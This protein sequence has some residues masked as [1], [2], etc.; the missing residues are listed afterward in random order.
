MSLT[1][2]RPERFPQPA[3]YRFYRQVY[4]YSEKK[5]DSRDA[6]MINKADFTNN[7]FIE[8]LHDVMPE[9]YRPWCRGFRA[10]ELLKKAAGLPS[11]SWWLP[12]T[13]TR[14]IG[15]CYENG[16]EKRQDEFL[17][18]FNR[19][20]PDSP[21]YN[22]GRV[23]AGTCET[24]DNCSCK[25]PE[26]GTPLPTQVLDF[27]FQKM[28]DRFTGMSKEEMIVLMGAHNLGAIHK[29]NSGFSTG[30]WMPDSDKLHVTFLH[31]MTKWAY[32]WEQHNVTNAVT[33]EENF[34]FHALGMEG[35][36]AKREPLPG[37]PNGYP[38]DCDEECYRE[39]RYHIDTN[40][41]IFANTFHHSDGT[42]K[43][44]S[45]IENVPSGYQQCAPQRCREDYDQGKDLQELFDWKPESVDPPRNFTRIS[46]V[47]DISM[48][49]NMSL[50]V[51]GQVI[52]GNG[53]V[54]R[55][56]RE[57]DYRADTFPFPMSK[58]FNSRLNRWNADDYSG[59]GRP[60][61]VQDSRYQRNQ[62]Y[63]ADFQ[64]D[65]WGAFDKMTKNG[66][67]GDFSGDE[68]LGSIISTADQTEKV[69]DLCSRLSFD[70]D[71][72]GKVV[73]NED[74]LYDYCRLASNGDRRLWSNDGVLGDEI[75]TTP[76]VYFVET[77]EEWMGTTTTTSTT[78]ES[79]TTTTTTESTTTTTTTTTSTT[80]PVPTTTASTTPIT[81]TTVEATTAEPTTTDPTTAE[82]TTTETTTTCVLTSFA[83][84]PIKSDQT[85]RL[86]DSATSSFCAF[87]KYSSYNVFDE[88][89]YA[90]C[91]V[92]NTNANK[93]A[94][95]KWSYDATTEMIQSV[96]AKEIMEKDLCWQVSNLARFGKQRLK[97]ANCDENEIRQKFSVVDGRLQ[98]AGEERLCVGVEEYRIDAV[99]GEAMITTLCNSAS[100][101]VCDHSELKLVNSADFSIA[102]FSDSE[103]CF[104]KRYT[105]YNNNDEI[106]IKPCDAQN[107]NPAKAGKYHFSFDQESGLIAS[108]GSR[109]N[110]PENVYCLKLN[111]NTRFGKQRIKITKCN[112]NDELQQ[113]VYRDGRIYSKGNSRLCAG[114]D[115]HFIPANGQTAFTF[116][117]CVPGLF[118]FE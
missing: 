91:D 117:T 41:T 69:L 25:L 76:L 57:V 18:T 77:G 80:A 15:D 98:M 11:Q 65:F 27:N 84:S 23:Y 1:A 106:W 101:G 66:Y 62:N 53:E 52:D 7:I 2:D 107:T 115:F 8:A 4:S 12:N 74:A 43:D 70:I 54:V 108:E 64:F 113:F 40:A 89:W 51:N 48:A 32:F 9:K 22:Y 72:Q 26:N 85:I 100:F 49:K 55:V 105:G 42:P 20:Y 73:F 16:V 87:K 10:R 111:S 56:S 79:T 34:E 6:P 59:D 13:S 3:V 78:T 47:S 58:Y 71:W 21:S 50:G 82:P 19:D 5:W 45:N 31:R 38:C 88:I 35:L 86:F 94:K 36:C 118:A 97:L 93:A 90:P 112:A 17:V 61:N 104:F 81:T 46:L 28:A 83:T 103:N 60:Y 116:R 102:P 37:R 109:V 14:T 95:Y 110:D 92:E 39:C 24:E 96:G 68:S 33:G 29:G 114:Y 30:P 75:I 67:Q 44:C 63:S 99:K